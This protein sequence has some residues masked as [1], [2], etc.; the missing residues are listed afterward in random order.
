MLGPTQD[1]QLEFHQRTVLEPPEDLKR[2]T[3]RPALIDHQRTIWGCTTKGSLELSK[4]HFQSHHRI[5]MPSK[6]RGK[7]MAFDPLPLNKSCE[8]SLLPILTSF[9]GH[10]QVEVCKSIFLT[11]SELLFALPSTYPSSPTSFIDIVNA[12]SIYL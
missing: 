9:S 12:P 7:A 2:T 4:S 10:S 5:V 11:S 6:I 8:V 1:H 3:R